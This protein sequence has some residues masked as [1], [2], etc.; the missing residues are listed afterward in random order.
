MKLERILIAASLLGFAAGA[1]AG[2]VGA[3]P[4]GVGSTLVGSAVT[5]GSIDDSLFNSPLPG[6]N[7]SVTLSPD[8]TASIAAY[9]KQSGG[10]Q[11]GAIITCPTRFA[12]G[13]DGVITLD[14]EKGTLTLTRV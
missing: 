7:G 11:D 3:G 10:T 6:V 8:Q 14:T 5:T 4:A 9:L 13:A 2:N 12:D 1:H